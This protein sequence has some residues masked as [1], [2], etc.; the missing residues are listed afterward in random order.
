VLQVLRSVGVASVMSRNFERLPAEITQSKATAFLQREKDWIIINQAEEDGKTLQELLPVSELAKYL[1][2]EEAQNEH[3]AKHD[4]D[5]A[6]LQD[7]LI[8]LLEIP[9][10]RLTITSISLQANLMEAHQAFSSGAE[11][12][13]VVFKEES[14]TKTS[15]VYGIITPQMIEAAYVPKTIRTTN[16]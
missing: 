9:A 11:I 6:P 10:K 16:D 4:V 8:N 15:R 3:E 1:R 14:I 2:I 12:L 5:D 13:C 7:P